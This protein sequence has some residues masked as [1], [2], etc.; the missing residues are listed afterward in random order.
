MKKIQM[1]PESYIKEDYY[2]IEREYLFE[3]L[4]HLVGGISCK[5]LEDNRYFL[6]TLAGR[7]IIILINEGKVIALK[8]SC[9]HRSGNFV[10]ERFGTIKNLTCVYHGLTFYKNGSFKSCASADDFC[11]NKNQ[12]N[13]LEDLFITKYPVQIIGELIFISINPRCAIEEQFSEEILEELSK[14]KFHNQSASALWQEEFNWKLFFE[15]VKDGLHVQYVHKNSFASIVERNYSLYQSNKSDYKERDSSTFNSPDID[16]DKIDIRDLSYIA[17]GKLNREDV[18]WAKYL[19]DIFK[20]NIYVNYFLFPST[21]FASVGGT[22][23]VRQRFEPC[24]PNLLNYE[25]DIYLPQLPN[26]FLSAPLLKRIIEIEKEI[27][28][29]D[30]I[31]LRKQYSNIEANIYDG[32]EQNMAHGD[33]EKSIIENILYINKLYRDFRK[34]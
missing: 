23:F 12:Y 6:T 19:K 32:I 10:N 15:N 3:G 9:P 18:W 25:L 24:A 21:N 20:H 8:N 34:K 28:E 2:E 7:E 16:L 11:S 30:S 4:W 14:F 1:I 26:Y 13:Q 27:I 22:H 17:N 31:I 5:Q 33:Y 29:E